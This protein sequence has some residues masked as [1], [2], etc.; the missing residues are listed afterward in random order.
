MSRNKKN[1]ARNPASYKKRTYRQLVNPGA[2]VS[3][4]VQVRETDLH[5]LAPLDLTTAAKDLVLQ[6]RNQLENYIRHCPSFKSSLVPLT[7]DLLAPPII[8]E[9]LK[10]AEAAEVG[11][12]AAVAGA[13]AEFVGRD[14][15]AMGHL[16]EIMV[17]N[18]GD[19]FLQRQTDCVIAIFA[20]P[21]PLSNKVGI[22]VAV[23]KMPLGICTSSATVGHSLSL[24]QAD[25]VTVLAAATALADAAATRIG[26]EVKEKHPLDEALSS[27]SQIPG[28]KGAVIIR[29][30]EIGAWGEIELVDLS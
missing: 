7:M 23:E 2:L 29:G 16:D 1:H 9:M 5:I 17:E 21:S 13:I 28:I 27:A 18:G 4:Q 30:L 11:P 20:G 19:I 26:N 3:C 8:K 14:L 25:A 24:G 10:A 6:Y 12:L 22:K 15:L